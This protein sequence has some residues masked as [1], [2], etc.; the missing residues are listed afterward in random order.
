MSLVVEFYWNTVYNKIVLVYEIKVR[1]KL[2]T[3]QHIS[4]RV[5]TFKYFKYYGCNSYEMDVQRE[6]CTV[7]ESDGTHLV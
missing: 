5:T 4:T 6:Y 3:K 2:L 7:T 1:K